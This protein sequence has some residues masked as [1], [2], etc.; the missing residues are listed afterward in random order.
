MADTKR[1]LAEL[2]TL[3]ADNATNDISAQDIRDFLVSVY[4][5]G[6]VL[7]ASQTASAVATL[8]FAT[9][10]APFQS[11]NLFQSDYDEYLVMFENVRPATASV[12]AY[13]R[14]TTDGGSTYDSSSIYSQSQYVWVS[15]S[16]TQSGNAA[17]AGVAQWAARQGTLEISNDAN[18]GVN[19][20]VT[21]FAPRSA[22]Y[23]RVQT[24]LNYFRASD[25]MHLCS[26]GAGGYASST[27]V[28]GFR[29]LFSSG[30]ITSGVVRV[31]GMKK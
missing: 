13:L 26:K 25:N 24:D 16:S 3:L 1:T 20:T 7:V 12:G 10:N 30:D 4:P 19:G 9:R 18:Y 17:S 29:F 31:Y 28:D 21:F 5:T 14:V 22:I 27:A 11:G 8:D 2:Q 15:N 6:M 23:K